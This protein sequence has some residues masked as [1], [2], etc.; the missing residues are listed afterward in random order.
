MNLKMKKSKLNKSVK[1][2]NTNTF[3]DVF[4]LQYLS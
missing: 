3:F 4:E 2:Q 1:I